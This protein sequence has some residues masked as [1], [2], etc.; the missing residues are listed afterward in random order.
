[1]IGWL[2]LVRVLLPL[3]IMWRRKP[4]RLLLQPCTVCVARARLRLLVDRMPLLLVSQR[5]KYIGPS[6]NDFLEALGIH[7]V[8]Q[9]TSLVLF[10]F[11][12]KCFS[13]DVSSYPF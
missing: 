8:H 4:L 2:L 5:L 13:I 12:G 9:L 3:P 7:H 1:M 6:D 11:V 10:V